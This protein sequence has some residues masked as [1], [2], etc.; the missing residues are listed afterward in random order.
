[1]ITR[2]KDFDDMVQSAQNAINSWCRNKLDENAKKEKDWLQKI[3]DILKARKYVTIQD[4]EGIL[5][6]VP[7]IAYTYSYL[8]FFDVCNEIHWFNTNIDP[9]ETEELKNTFFI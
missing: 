7:K 5:R 6:D 3:L 4:S 2:Y 8:S 9:I 1:M